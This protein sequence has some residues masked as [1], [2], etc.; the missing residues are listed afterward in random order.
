MPSFG[1][2]VLGEAIS[3]NSPAFHSSFFR[4]TTILY[5][6]LSRIIDMAAEQLKQPLI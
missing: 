3:D 5:N 1:E 2:T 4:R 6:Y